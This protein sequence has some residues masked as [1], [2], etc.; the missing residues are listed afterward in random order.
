MASI[1]IVQINCLSDN[2][3]YLVHDPESGETAC[4]DTPETEPLLRELNAR[5]WSLTYIWNCF[6]IKLQMSWML[7]VVSISK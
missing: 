6:S 4:I 2:Y 5:G 7:R 3:G 1:E